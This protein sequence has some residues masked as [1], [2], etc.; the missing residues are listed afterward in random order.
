MELVTPTGALL[1]TGHAASFGPMPAMT[2]RQTGYG[3]GSREIEGHPN[4]LRAVVG[5]TQEAG[6][7]STVA[8]LECNIDDMNP[9]VFGYL[10]DRLYDLGA[11]DVFYTAVQMKKSRPGTLVTVITPVSLREAAL[12]VLFEETTT[13]GV[14]HQEMLRE[15]LHREWTTVSTRYGEVRIKIARRGERV[16][17]AAPEFEDCAR[18]AAAQKVP[19]KDVHAA[20]TRAYLDPAV[21]GADET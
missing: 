21:R 12:D 13:I 7:S 17:N 15:C 4:V 20:A 5:E 14:R 3:A 6:A 8:V 11:L 16:T 1:V 2:V 10:L 9:Q 19:V 18:L